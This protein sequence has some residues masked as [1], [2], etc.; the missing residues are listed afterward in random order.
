MHEADRSLSV[1]FFLKPRENPRKSKDAGRPIFDQIE[2]VSIVAPGNSK[3]EA[4]FPAEEVHF[5][6]NE[7]MQMTYIERFPEQYDAFKRG[8]EAHMVGTPLAS[9]DFMTMQP[10]LV[11]E[12]NAAKIFTVEQLAGMSDTNIRKMGPNFRK[13]VNDAKGYLEHANSGAALRDELDALRAQ[14]AA[15]TNDAPAG[16]PEDDGFASYTD[17]DL[18]NMIRDA[19]GDMPRSN[20]KRASLVKVLDE[21][22]KKADE[23]AA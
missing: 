21:L 17:E 7:Q 18:R 12:M 4:N 2:M 5:N 23:K 15:L 13:H 16:E 3:T 14:L 8:V 11:A 6:G 22:T 1:K 20:A 9:A 10:A 19:G